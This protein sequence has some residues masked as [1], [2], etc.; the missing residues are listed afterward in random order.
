VRVSLTDGRIVGGLYDENSVAGYSQE[1]P[2]LYLSRRWDLDEDYWFLGPADHSLGIWLP[3][4]SIASLEIYDIEGM[5]GLKREI[6]K[7]RS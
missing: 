1:V 4:E 6:P 3:R 7:I 2:D 5:G